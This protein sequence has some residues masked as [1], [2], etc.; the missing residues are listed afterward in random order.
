MRL[1]P[2]CFLCVISHPPALSILQ[3]KGKLNP[4]TIHRAVSVRRGMKTLNSF[5]KPRDTS[6]PLC[7]R[8]QAVEQLREALDRFHAGSGLG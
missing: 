8:E 7:G 6:L 2:L 3:V 4:V 5:T 1:T